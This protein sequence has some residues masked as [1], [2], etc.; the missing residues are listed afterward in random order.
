LVEASRTT[1]ERNRQKE[2]EREG[3]RET[4]RPA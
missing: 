4:E 3:T 1:L 2:R